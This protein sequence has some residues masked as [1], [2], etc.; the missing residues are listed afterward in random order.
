MLSLVIWNSLI[1][2]SASYCLKFKF[3]DLFD[4]FLITVSFLVSFVPHFL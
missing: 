2:L 3:I 1:L 4:Y